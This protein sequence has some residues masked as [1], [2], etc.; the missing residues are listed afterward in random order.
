MGFAVMA[1]QVIKGLILWIL[2]LSRSKGWN[3]ATMYLAKNEE[4]PHLS[5]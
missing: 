1:L 4:I 5:E 2:V 3:M